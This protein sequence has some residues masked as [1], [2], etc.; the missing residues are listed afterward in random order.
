MERGA[1][2]KYTPDTRKRSTMVPLAFRTPC[3]KPEGFVPVCRQPQSGCAGKRQIPASRGK[4][5]FLMRLR[6][7]VVQGLLSGSIWA[8]GQNK[9]GENMQ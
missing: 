2:G 3:R 5:H 4:F 7:G 9:P 8:D 6:A 1:F